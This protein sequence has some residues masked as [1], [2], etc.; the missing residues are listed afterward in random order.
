MPRPRRPKLS[1]GSIRNL[2]F[3]RSLTFRRR[4]VAVLAILGIYALIRFVPLPVLPCELSPAKECVPDDGAI[5]FVPA[6]VYAYAHLNLDPDSSQVEKAD[7][8]ADQLPHVQGILEGAY[9]AAAP[10]S[11]L[12][13]SADVLPW[14]EDE[15]AGA[16]VPDEGGAPLPLGVFEIGDQR[17]AEQFLASVGGATPVAQEYR[18]TEIASYSDDLASAESG[19]FLLL[20]D[21]GAVRAAIDADRGGDGPLEESKEAERIRDA[22][23]EHR[24]ADVYVSE[25]GISQLLAGAGGLSPQLDTFTDFGSSVGIA[26][27]AVAE[28]DGLRIDLHSRLDPEQ[29]RAEPGFFAAFPSFDPELA[30]YFAPSTLAVLQI[31]PPSKTIRGLLEQADAAFPGIAGAFDRINEQLAESGGV[32]IENGVLPLLGGEAAVG[33]APATPVPYATA[34]FADVDE[35]RAREAVARLAVPLIAGLDPATTGQAPVFSRRRVEGVTVNTLRVSRALVPSYAV[36]DDHLVVST[37]PRGVAEAIEGGD[38]LGSEPG[39]EAVTNGGGGDVSALVFLNLE[40]LVNLA[41][42]LG[43]AEIVD[44][45]RADLTRLN[46]FGVTV[47]SSDDRLDTQLFLNIE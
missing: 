20:G 39:Y 27:A 2:W 11:P 5:A 9:R 29:A 21:P 3:G 7:E 18:G 25:E 32:D 17:G 44:D 38:D 45:F 24:L 22:L 10:E 19:G 26:A 14:I 28:G 4:A 47:E 34:V 6:D 30:R 36:F 13:V 43:L 40:G 16:I 8:L 15:A 33:V 37:D 41:E 42:P 1:A 35:E 12:T 31:G 23:P 46:A